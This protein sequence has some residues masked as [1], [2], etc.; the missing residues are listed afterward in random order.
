MF[1][2]CLVIFGQVII[3]M[4]YSLKI[5]AYIEDH[6]CAPYKSEDQIKFDKVIELFKNTK[7]IE[8]LKLTI[9]FYEFFACIRYL[10][11]DWMVFMFTLL[12]IDQANM[13]INWN[14]GHMFKKLSKNWLT[15]DMK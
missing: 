12:V 4:W 14:D 1:N 8:Y 10:I 13:A 2:A 9:S 5:S 6:K 15:F 3:N 11:M 7:G